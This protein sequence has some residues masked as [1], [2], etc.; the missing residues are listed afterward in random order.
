MAGGEVTDPRAFTR[1]AYAADLL[2]A[3]DSGYDYLREMG[4]RPHLLVGDL[5]S[6][7][8][9]AVRDAGVHG[10][11]VERFPAEKDYTDTELA[12][13]KAVERGART[14]IACG[15]FGR[16]LDHT[17][18]NILLLAAPVFRAVDLRMLDEQQEVR[19]VRGQLSLH[20]APGEVIS[21][22]PVGGEVRGV[23]TS[24]LCYRL[25]DAALHTGPALGV[26]NVSTHDSVT[27][28]VRSGLLLATRIFKGGLNDAAYLLQNPPT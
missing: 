28:E 7:T 9:E 1:I 15:M 12:L 21:L 10:V 4:V 27:V 6:I 20:S 13:R 24:G 11:P 8:S 3:A 23:T 19:L 18:A 17:L 22:L 25:S 16:R 5:D 26:S 2:I 14:I